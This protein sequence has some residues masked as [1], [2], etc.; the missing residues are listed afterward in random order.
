MHGFELK[1]N[2]AHSQFETLEYQLATWRT[3]GGYGVIF[4]PQTNSGEYIIRLHAED[5]PDALSLIIGDA[6]HAMRSGLDHLA[7]ALAATYTKPL[8]DSVRER[9]EFPIFGDRPMTARERSRK[10]GGLDPAAV[11]AIDKLQPSER[12][13]AYAQDA[14]WTLY[15][16]ARIDRHR[17][18]HLTVAQLDRVGVGG[19]NVYVEH[20]LMDNITTSAKDGTKLG[21]CT[22]RAIDP[23]RPTHLEITTEP[24]IAFQDGPKAGQPVLDVL[25]DIHQHL[26]STVV[27]SLRPFLN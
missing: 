26:E 11:A 3:S 27:P 13:N 23:S 12:G 16:L 4:D 1:L 5:P 22:V 21:R 18:L 2:W 8:P 7:Y 6:L 17:L 20:L 15:D 9:I 14:L 19:D 10:L 25:R 24:Q